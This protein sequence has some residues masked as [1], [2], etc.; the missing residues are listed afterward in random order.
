MEV[1]DG[2]MP[3]LAEGDSSIIHLLCVLT[4]FFLK[5][6][7]LGLTGP[8]SIQN[9]ECFARMACV[10]SSSRAMYRA[11]PARTSASERCDILA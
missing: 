1:F 5:I 6:P 8:T 2:N 3:V 7:Y 9:K 11:L 4:K 10:F